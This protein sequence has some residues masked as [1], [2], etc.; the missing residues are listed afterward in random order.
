MKTGL[1][2][3]NL[4]AS[5]IKRLRIPESTFVRSRLFSGFSSAMTLEMALA[6]MN[7]HEDLRLK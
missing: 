3:L 5:A 1:F 4:G 6:E 7:F 2:R